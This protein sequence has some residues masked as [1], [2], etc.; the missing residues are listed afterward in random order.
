MGA[1]YNSDELYKTFYEIS[2]KIIFQDDLSESIEITKEMIAEIIIE[3]EYHKSYIP[4]LFMKLILDP[5]Q[6]RILDRLKGFYNIHL[7]ASTGYAE[8]NSPTLSEAGNI[9]FNTVFK[10]DK[11]DSPEGIYDVFTSY[12]DKDPSKEDGNDDN[13]L[14]TSWFFLY[15]ETA[16]EDNKA[17]EDNSHTFKDTTVATTAGAMLT[18]G[19]G[20]LPIHFEQPDN[21]TPYTQVKISNANLY[22]SLY[23]VLQNGSY[24]MYSKGMLFFN[25]FDKIYLMSRY[26]ENTPDEGEPDLVTIN[27]EPNNKLG[28]DGIVVTDRSSPILVSCNRNYS[29][30]RNSSIDDTLPNNV[31]VFSSDT[32]NDR[33]HFDNESGKWNSEVIYDEFRY[34]RLDKNAKLRDK[35]E[36]IF[37]DDGNL[38]KISSMHEERSHRTVI[39]IHMYDVDLAYLKPNLKYS[40]NFDLPV[41]DT[42][43][44][45]E[46]KL[47]KYITAMTYDKG[48]GYHVGRTI[49]QFK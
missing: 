46:Y 41:Y 23:N 13:P 16:L 43:F 36:Y 18:S 4:S 20:V 35:K 27:I 39:G 34:D 9:I 3:K 26:G 15:D 22:L 49:M 19:A 11:A 37:S 42:K 47:F 48:M 28:Q 14:D 2:G 38:Y 5:T 7:S 6:T 40:I 24:G 17:R 45:G 10:A 32:F 25:D 1:S 31:R 21:D 12:D 30:T 44:G 8:Q 33:V 29:M